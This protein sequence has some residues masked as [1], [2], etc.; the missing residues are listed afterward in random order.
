MAKRVFALSRS[1]D[2][3]ESER[4]PFRPAFRHLTNI[5]QINQLSLEQTEQYYREQGH[6]VD[7]RDEEA[8]RQRATC[9]RHWIEHYA[10]ED[11]KFSLNTSAPPME[12]TPQQRDFIRQFQETLTELEQLPPDKELHEAIYSIIEKVG[13]EPKDI[14]ACLYQILISK[15]RG[16]KLANFIC[17]IGLEKTL[18]IL[19]SIKL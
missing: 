18:A 19:K 1:A 3:P 2:A 5:L 16:P 13:A 9:A 14:F 7:S 17:T 8:F 6:L 4:P 10:P 11:F 12:L 15:P